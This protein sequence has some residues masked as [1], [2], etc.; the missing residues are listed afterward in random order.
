MSRDL[1]R[2]VYER[3]GA[4]YYVDADG[5]WHKLARVR[6]GLPAMYRAL[7]ELTDTAAGTELM[8]AVIVRWLDSKRGDWSTEVA[9]DQ[10]RVAALLSKRFADLAPAQV[11]AKHCRDYL[12][13]LA[14]KARTHNMH[15]TMLVEVLSF[16]AADGLREGHNPATDTKRIKTKQRVRIVVDDEIEA[17][18]KAALDLGEACSAVP[19]MLEL[20]LLTGQRISDLIGITWS[21]VADDGVR[22]VQEKTGARLLIEWSPALRAAVDACADKWGRTGHLLKSAHGKGWSYAGIWKQFNLARNAAGVEG[23]RIHDLRGR[24][25]VDALLANDEDV[26]AAQRLLGHKGEA[27]TRR[28]TDG[29]YHR[30]AKPPR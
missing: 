15:R 5:K 12:K 21:S 8:P 14:A 24:A 4:W 10:E 28:Y 1:P 26:R 6:Q 29:K 19:L 25:G 3:H 23:L 9:K 11:T 13:P 17:L 7:A 16:A 20:A 18:R 30:R 2:R 27:M 22:I